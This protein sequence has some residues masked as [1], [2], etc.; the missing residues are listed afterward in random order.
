MRS[1]PEAKGLV[2]VEGGTVLIRRRSTRV[3]NIDMRCR[4][5]GVNGRV[6]YE[7]RAAA[8]SGDHGSGCAGATGDNRECSRSKRPH[9]RGSRTNRQRAG[10]CRSGIVG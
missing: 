7:N 5:R 6:S 2:R 9:D 4:S 3:H 10:V 8:T 1:P